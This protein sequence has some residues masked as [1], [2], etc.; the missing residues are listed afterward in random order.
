M[1]FCLLDT[2]LFPGCLHGLFSIYSLSNLFY[3]I[4]LKFQVKMEKLATH[5]RTRN[6]EDDRYECFFASFVFRAAFIIT[7]TSEEC[8]SI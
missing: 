1:L 3:E 2:H 7:V 4:C 6:K 8:P 5:E